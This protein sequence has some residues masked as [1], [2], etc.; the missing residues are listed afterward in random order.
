MSEPEDDDEV[1]VEDD[2]E[3]EYDEEDE[4]E[5]EYRRSRDSH[6]RFM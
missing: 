6:G 3:V 1:E 2:E 4:M 5:E